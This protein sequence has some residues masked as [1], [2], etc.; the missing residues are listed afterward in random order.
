M[1]NSATRAPERRASTDAPAL[2]PEELRGNL[3][4]LQTELNGSMKCPAGR[5]QVYVRSL[6]TIQ[7]TTPPRIAL[8][9]GLR[10]D[11]GES[12]DVFLDEIRSK[13]CGDPEQCAAHRAFQNRRIPT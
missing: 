11:I 6:V 12:A 13:C 5:N 2:R 10:R 1:R 4:Q 9:C 7:G 8:K 3:S